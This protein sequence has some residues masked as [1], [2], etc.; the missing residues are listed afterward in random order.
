[1][2]ISLSSCGKKETAQE[3]PVTPTPRNPK[4]LIA[5][6]CLTLTNPFENH[7][8]AMEDEAAKHGSAS[9]LFLSGDY[10]VAKQRNQIKDFIVRGADAIAHQSLR[11]QSHRGRHQGIQ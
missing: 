1:M 5:A 6:T 10:D 3:E 7:Q 4:G 2:A 11:Q 8:E 9:V